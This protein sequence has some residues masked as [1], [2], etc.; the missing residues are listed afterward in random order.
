ML[1]PSSSTGCWD[2]FYD[3]P[4]NSTTSPPHGGWVD[5]GAEYP[6]GSRDLIGD[7]TPPRT[8]LWEA[9]QVCYRRTCGGLPATACAR[10]SGPRVLPWHGAAQAPNPLPLKW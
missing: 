10:G 8:P 7:P 5:D 9:W 2:T 1:T 6:V 4:R 3:A